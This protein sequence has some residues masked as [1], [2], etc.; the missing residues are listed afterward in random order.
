[1]LPKTHQTATT[2][3]LL[4]LLAGCRTFGPWRDDP[5]RPEVNIVFTVERNLL[6]LPSVEINGRAGRYFLGSAHPRSVFDPSLIT[7]L[8]GEKPRLHLTARESLPLSPVPI[9]LGP[10]GDAIIGA[11][12][13]GRK[14]LTIDYYAGLVTYHK[15][16]SYTSDMKLHRFTGEPSIVIEVDG[17]R[18]DAA[19][20]T[21]LPDTLVM[22]R[23][24]RPAGR[25]RANLRIDEAQ[26]SNIDIALG[27]VSHARIG[28]RLLSRFLVTIDYG[29]K[30]VGL[31]RDPRIGPP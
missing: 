5:P 11:E 2:G 13:W 12:A 6:R 29:Q 1:M 20:D 3:F 18:M 30:Q 10:I 17:V 23:G 24:A 14:S 28:N 15:S 4:I 27:N 19:V 8:A 25:T 16:G 7:S 22:P 26:F 21:A 31:W 9:A